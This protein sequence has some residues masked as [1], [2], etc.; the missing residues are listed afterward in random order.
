M[1]GN[2]EIVVE[3][4]MAVAKLRGDAD[5]AKEWS[6]RVVTKASHE[7]AKVMR[8]LVPRGTSDMFIGYDTLESRIDSSKAIWHPGGL[9]GG[10]EWEAKAGVRRSPRYPNPMEDP[11]AYVYEGTGLFGPFKRL[12]VPRSGNF[13][14]FKWHGRMVFTKYVKGQEPQRT[15]VI[16]AQERAN[17]VIAS[18]LAIFNLDRP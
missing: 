1:S 17:A 12:I 4:H 15:W 11:A 13:L 5:R 7:A 16:A 2:F 8:F 18:A 10:G 14:A 6:Q 9:G 3:D